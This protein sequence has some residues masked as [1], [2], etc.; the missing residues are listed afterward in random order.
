MRCISS[1]PTPWLLSRET[2]QDC[3]FGVRSVCV[4]VQTHDAKNL[5]ALLLYGDEGH[6]VCAI[7][8]G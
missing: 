4:V 5:A 3:K 6:G 7:V 2:H 8:I 1:Q